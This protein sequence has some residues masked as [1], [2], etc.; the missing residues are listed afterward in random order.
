LPGSLTRD[1]QQ[2]M[3]LAAAELPVRRTL[4][5]PA[6]GVPPEMQPCALEQWQWDGIE[7]TVEVDADGRACQ[8]HARA[9]AT[10]LRLGG[11]AATR[12]DEAPGMTLR[13]VMDANGIHRR[14]G[15]L[16]L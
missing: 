9:G 4:V 5:A 2:A 12:L 14:H 8:L 16:R 11:D 13:L 15:H 3:A 6:R 1:V 7:F 10:S